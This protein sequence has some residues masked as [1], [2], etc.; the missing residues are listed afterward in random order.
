ME[1]PLH[2]FE[3]YTL[4]PLRLAGIDI[5]LTNSALYMLGAAF[6]SLGFFWAATHKARLIPSSLQSLAELTY[7]VAGNMV[8]ENVGPKGRPFI[9]FVLSVFMFILLG[10]LLGMLPYGFTF[11]SQIILTLGMAVLIFSLI[12][13]TG[14]FLHGWRFFKIFCPEGAPPLLLP[15]LIPIE[16]LSF[17]SRPVSLSIRLFAN[18]MAGHTML[19][20]FALFT[21]T[22]GVWGASTILLN[23]VL[24]AFEILVAFLQAYVFAVLTCLYLNDAI[25][26]HS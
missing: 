24:I 11:T 18:M 17:L 19:K 5:S 20:V 1:S 6:L 25:H 4:V 16:I 13:A 3:I 12:I 22:L 2:Q 23:S 21:I 14:L 15:L 8:E 26:L 7:E 10:N 9:P